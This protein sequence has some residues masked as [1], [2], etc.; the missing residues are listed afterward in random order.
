MRPDVR[1]LPGATGG[2]SL[3]YEVREGD[4]VLRVDW[5]PR[6]TDVF[7]Y[8]YFEEWSSP[9]GEP[10][11]GADR[12]RVLAALW[13]VVAKHGGVTAIIDESRDLRAPRVAQWNRGEDGH[14]I[15]VNDGGE[16]L[17][18]ERRRSLRL[19]FRRRDL[20]VAVVAWPAQPRWTEPDA[21]VTPEEEVVVCRRLLAATSRDMRIG[22]H[23][24]W[25]IVV[26]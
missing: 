21:P 16:L 18:M 6:E 15:D 26:A 17:Y 13:P 5:D 14:L 12:E 11:K 9:A 1:V 2:P 22:K 7:L 8:Q 20:Y 4:H 10:L 24:P 19:S 25:R 3:A 23:L